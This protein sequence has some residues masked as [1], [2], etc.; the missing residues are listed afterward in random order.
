MQIVWSFCFSPKVIPNRERAPMYGW[1]SCCLALWTDE[2]ATNLWSNWSQGAHLITSSDQRWAAD[3]IYWWI[4]CATSV[5]SQKENKS[6]DTSLLLSWVHPLSKQHT[7]KSY[8]LCDSS[9]HG[10]R[11]L[12]WWVLLGPA[13]LTYKADEHFSVQ[14]HFWV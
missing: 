5:S 9:Y 8:R 11:I 2:E 10:L 13:D 14:T 12:M 7:Q 4:P 3:S 6:L 1:Q